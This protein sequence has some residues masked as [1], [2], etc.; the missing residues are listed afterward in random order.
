MKYNFDNQPSRRHT[1]S[2]KWDSSDD[3][4][5]LPLW[6]ADMDFTTCPSIT[7]ALERRVRHGIFGYTKVGD[8][9]YSAVT[10]WFARRHAFSIDKEWVIYTSGVVPAISAAIKALTRPGDKVLVQ[11]PVYNCFFSS[12]RN[13]GCGMV[14]SPLVRTGNTYAI[15]F[16]DL[17]DKAADP[18]VKVMLLCNPHNPACRVW[19]RDELTRIGDICLRHGVC[20][21]LLHTVC[22]HQRGVSPPFCHLCLSKQGLQHSRTADSQHHRC[23]CRGAPQDR[24]R[25]QRQ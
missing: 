1:S 10:G 22:L 25:H 23:R 3:S 18:A 8:D 11:T 20:P 24:P 16:T 4:T 9:Y 2:Y 5:L 19:T 7:E 17:E 21:A 6:V 15:D 14:S 13:N 12:I